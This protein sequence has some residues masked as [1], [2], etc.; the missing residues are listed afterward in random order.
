MSYIYKI[1]NDINNL[2]YIG[3]TTGSILAR[4]LQH[5]SE[6]RYDVNNKF[7]KAMNE[8][9]IEHFKIEEIEKCSNELF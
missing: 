5:C 1:S 6:S 4:F 9:G 3:Q 7:H 2:I 8:L